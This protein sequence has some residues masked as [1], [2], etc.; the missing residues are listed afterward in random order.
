[1]RMLGSNIN[2]QIAHQLVAQCRTINH[3]LNGLDDQL[4]GSFA[5]EDFA[6]GALLDAAR[7]TGVVVEDALLGLVAGQSDLLGID[8]NDVVTAI[9]EGGIAGLVF[10]LEKHGDLG[11]Q[12]AEDE[13]FRVNQ[14]PVFLDLA[15]LEHHGFHGEYSRFRE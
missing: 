12:A 9:E 1:M 2:A 14:Q 13:V 7:I 5:R 11:S 15:S 4:L 6:F 8:D 10:A 3:A